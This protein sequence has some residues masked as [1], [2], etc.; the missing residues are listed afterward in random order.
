MTSTRDKAVKIFEHL[1]KDPYYQKSKGK[2]REEVVWTEAQQRARQAQN[3]EMALSMA[4]S[5]DESGAV[6]SLLDFMTK[7]DDTPKPTKAT[8]QTHISLSKQSQKA[9]HNSTALTSLQK[10]LQLIREV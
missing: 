2:T 6:K 5:D 4:V 3:N 10:I 9:V 7:A 8:P 1:I